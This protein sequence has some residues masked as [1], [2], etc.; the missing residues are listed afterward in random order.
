MQWMDFCSYGFFPLQNLPSHLL[1]F[2]SP[3]TKNIS[4]GSTQRTYSLSSALTHRSTKIVK[5]YSMVCSKSRIGNNIINSIL[6]LFKHHRSPTV[7]QT[8]AW[9]C[10]QRAVQCRMEEA[11][12]Y[13]RLCYGNHAQVTFFQAETLF[14]HLPMPVKK[15]TRLQLSK[16]LMDFIFF[17][18]TFLKTK[19][20]M[21]KQTIRLSL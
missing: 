19:F 5:C 1:T 10:S 20:Y 3:Q 21:L 4:K 13:S 2:F 18:L 8:E 15:K 16:G 17:H 14:C 12:C 11:M 9:Y 7:L 6:G